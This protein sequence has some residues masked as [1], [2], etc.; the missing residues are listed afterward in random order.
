M[1][2]QPLRSVRLFQIPF[3][4]AIRLLARTIQGRSRARTRFLEDL[5]NPGDLQLRKDKHPRD[6]ISSFIRCFQF[7]GTQ[8]FLE[9]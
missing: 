4:N 1:L 9:I 8:L 5:M 2:I 6:E 3:N 7:T